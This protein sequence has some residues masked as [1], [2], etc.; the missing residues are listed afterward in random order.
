MTAF[1]LE[2]VLAALLVLACGLGAALYRRLARLRAEQAALMASIETF[3]AAT[4]RAEATLKAMQT[5]G[6]TLE[7][8]LG[9]TVARA[10]FLMDELTVMV[11]A[12]DNIAGRIE[13]AMEDVRSVARTA[14]GSKSATTTRIRAHG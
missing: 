11:S 12:G 2:A 10:N 4:R 3:D 8:S 5:R 1:V 9:K 14:R 6:T 7:T 13:G